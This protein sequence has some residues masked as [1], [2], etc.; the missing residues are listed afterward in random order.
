MSIDTNTQPSLDSL[1]ARRW[2][3]RCLSWREVGALSREEIWILEY[4]IRWAPFGGAPPGELLIDFGVARLRFM[5]MVHAA[6]NP[7]PAEASS[8]ANMKRFLRAA[9]LR[10]WL[11]SPG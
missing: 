2:W 8:I 5:E 1:W 6:L 4:A 9:L 3:E 7:A 11:A 10:A